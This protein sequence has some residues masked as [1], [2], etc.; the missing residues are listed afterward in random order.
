MGYQ[1][2]DLA[3]LAARASTFSRFARRARIFAVM[4]A[5]GV[6]TTRQKAP[7]FRKRRKRRRDGNSDENGGA[8]NSAL[9][10]SLRE[11]FSTRSRPFVS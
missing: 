4:L 5:Y 6:V 2:R 8:T 10:F 11:H 1:G 3:F 7:D 9:T